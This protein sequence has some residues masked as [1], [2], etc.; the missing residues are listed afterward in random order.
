MD[1]FQWLGSS[2]PEI[3]AERDAQLAYARNFAVVTLFIQTTA[4]LVIVGNY[5]AAVF[6]AIWATFLALCLG[7]PPAPSFLPR[8]S[9]AIGHQFTGAAMAL[10]GI[11][12]QTM[13]GMV[14]Y[15]NVSRI[16]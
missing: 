8:A 4:L 9:T 1:F 15:A 10:G 5:P 16:H 12:F 11:V 3:V 13:L 14:V 7:M 2:A 6:L